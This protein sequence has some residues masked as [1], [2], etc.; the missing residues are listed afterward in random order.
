MCG[1][2]S[3]YMRLTQS[4]THGAHVRHSSFRHLFASLPRP[5]SRSSLPRDSLLSLRSLLTL[6]EQLM[7]NQFKSKSLMCSLLNRSYLLPKH[8]R[9]TDGTLKRIKTRA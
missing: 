2:F 4:Q 3:A 5:S 6:G 7:D 1:I 8:P 9:Q